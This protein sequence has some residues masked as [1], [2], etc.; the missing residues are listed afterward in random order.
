MSRFV[1]SPEP[2]PSLDDMTAAKAALR[3]TGFKD[4]E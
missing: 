3:S 1:E 4:T 2:T